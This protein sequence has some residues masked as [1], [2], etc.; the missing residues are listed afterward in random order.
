MEAASSISTGDAG[1][2]SDVFDVDY[3]VNVLCADIV[4]YGAVRGS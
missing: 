3:R 1:K 2:T 4:G